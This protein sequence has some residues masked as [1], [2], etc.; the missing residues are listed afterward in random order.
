MIKA[1]T[2]LFTK[3]QQSTNTTLER[4]ECSMAGIID[5]LTLWRL[6]YPEQI[7]T[8]FQTKLVRTTTTM[9]M[10]RW[11]MMRSPS[12]LHVHH[13]DGRTAMTSRCAKSFHAIHV[14]QIPR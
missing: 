1:L 2:E 5:A 13:H 11:W 14:D 12:T 6:D 8:S 10:R 9:T 7:K 3:N 4:V